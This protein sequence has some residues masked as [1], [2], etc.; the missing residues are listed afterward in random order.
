MT[1]T[2][3]FELEGELKV[4]FTMQLDEFEA[5][6]LHTLSDYNH[7]TVRRLLEEHVTSN[8]S[9]NNLRGQAVLTLLAKAKTLLPLLQRTTAARN[10][11]NN[12]ATAVN[13][14]ID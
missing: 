3:A 7:E 2:P 5:R 9:L 14:K 4:V 10:V 13:K 8:F 11:F 6:A 12:L 1:D